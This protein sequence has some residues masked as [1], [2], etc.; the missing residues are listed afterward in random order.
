MA[1]AHGVGV[2]TL[3]NHQN[4]TWLARPRRIVSQSPAAAEVEKAVETKEAAEP[5][6]ADEI[7][8]VFA[9]WNDGAPAL[10][11]LIEYVEAV[12]GILTLI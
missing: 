10:E 5:K 8:D 9:D 12:T 3:A 1:D 11:T 2:P 4:A 6:E 7:E